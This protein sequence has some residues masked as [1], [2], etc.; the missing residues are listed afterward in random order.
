MY[1]FILGKNCKA[2]AAFT[3]LIQVVTPL[4]H[5]PSLPLLHASFSSLKQPKI[6]Q[7][8][9]MLLWNVFK[10]RLENNYKIIAELFCLHFR[11]FFDEGILCPPGWAFRKTL[12]KIWLHMF[13]ELFWCD[14]IQIVYDPFAN[15]THHCKT[16]AHV[17]VQVPL[18]PWDNQ[19]QK[20]W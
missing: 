20:P 8:L 7:Q 11:F 6:D 4:A 17:Q 19:L 1:T 3:F 15:F 13:Q 16:Q 14:F 2:I 5:F 9:W 18:L 12:P 10:N